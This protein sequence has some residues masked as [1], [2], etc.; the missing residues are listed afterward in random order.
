MRKKLLM[1][2][3][4]CSLS[5]AYAD[6]KNGLYIGGS[7][8]WGITN[9]SSTSPSGFSPTNDV[10]YRVDLGARIDTYF[11]IE[12]GYVAPSIS[13]NNLWLGDVM[14]N[15]YFNTDSK[16]DVLFGVGPFYDSS[17]GAV[18]VAGSFGVNYN[19]ARNLALTFGEYLYINPQV[20]S[21]QNGNIS[22]Y[23]QNNVTTIGFKVIM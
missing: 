19:F 23:L 18:G 17:L 11:G 3:L 1:S 15:Y 8:G 9:D 7:G 2:L 14:L 22:A 12:A 5:I 21:S 6:S 13:N 10:A 4:C 16:W 20:P